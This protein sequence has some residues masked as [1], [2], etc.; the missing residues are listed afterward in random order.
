MTKLLEATELHTYYGSS[1]VLRGVT[2]AIA[3]GEAVALSGRNGMGKT[4]T[5]RSVLGLTPPRAGG[6]VV[7]GTNVMGWAA[8]RIARM[9]IALVPE[10]R[11]IFPPL[12]AAENLVVAPRP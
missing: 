4:T 8:H 5:I 3:E 6:V 7:R 9:G 2:F 12:T 11:G 10:G 1:H